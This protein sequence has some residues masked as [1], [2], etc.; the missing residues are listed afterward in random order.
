M[1]WPKM[2]F[3]RSITSIGHLVW[4][5][6]N[7]ISPEYYLL[8]DKRPPKCGHSSHL[9]GVYGHPSSHTGQRPRIIIRKFVTSFKY[10]YWSGRSLF[11]VK[12]NRFVQNPICCSHLE[13]LFTLRQTL[14]ILSKE[15]LWLIWG[16]PQ[17][18]CTT[19]SAS[20]EFWPGHFWTVLGLR[21]RVKLI[22][23]TPSPLWLNMTRWRNPIWV[24]SAF[25]SSR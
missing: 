1:F 23:C 18:A 17:P 8:T 21:N 13:V 12:Q 19:Y 15:A 2:A 5:R 3:H 24:Q 10:V 6:V 16:W 9:N 25:L 4:L 11:Q 22:A 7:I 14:C 20:Q